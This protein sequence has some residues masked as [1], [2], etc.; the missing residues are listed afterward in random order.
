VVKYATH[1]HTHFI[2]D[3]SSA[4]CRVLVIYLNEERSI[5][6]SLEFSSFAMASQIHGVTPRTNAHHSDPTQHSSVKTAW[7]F[8]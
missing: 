2:T 6:S 3:N 7:Q 1:T 4:M 8:D 5:H